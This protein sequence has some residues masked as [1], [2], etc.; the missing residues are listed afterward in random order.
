MISRFSTRLPIPVCVESIHGSRDTRTILSSSTSHQYVTVPGTNQR[1]SI[2]PYLEK[3]EHQSRTMPGEKLE[4]A[5][6]T[7]PGENKITG[8]PLY[9]KPLRNLSSSLL[10]LSQ[11]GEYFDDS[12]V[13][14]CSY[15][16]KAVLCRIIS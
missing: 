8:I 13:R 4:H 9:I 14:F 6:K 11:P 12:K 5:H 2:R 10:S 3:Q 7:I 16:N 1:T 15:S